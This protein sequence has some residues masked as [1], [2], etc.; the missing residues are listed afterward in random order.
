MSSFP[1]QRVVV[2]GVTSSGKSTLAEKLAKCFDLNY[3]E[4]DALNWEPN[5]QAAPLEVFRARVEAALA[6]SSKWIV[7]GNYHVVRDLTWSRA[8][9]V[10]WLDYSIW[11]VLWQMTLRSLRR[12]WTRELLWGTNYEPFWIHLKLWST[13]SLYHWLFKT[14]WRRKRE[15]PMLLSQPEYRHLKLLRFTHPDETEEWIKNL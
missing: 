12:A 8:E 3:I 15:Y 7:A 1:Y 10:I 4:L 13:D 2:V 11:R 5:W 9:A 14:Y 6:Q